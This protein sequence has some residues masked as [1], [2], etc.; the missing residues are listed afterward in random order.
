MI[1]KAQSRIFLSTLLLI[2]FL[3]P[4]QKLTASSSQAEVQLSAPVRISDDNGDDEDPSVMLARDGR[5]YVAWSSKRQDGVNIYIKSSAD[6][7]TWSTEE[8]VTIGPG[9]DY[10]P[11]LAQTRDGTFHIAWF[12]LERA[13]ADIDIWFSR[14]QD[15][16]TWSIPVQITT[17]PKVEWAPS[18]LAD[19][20]DTLRIVWSSGK[21]GN[22]ELFV[23][24]SDDGG[25]QW[26]CERQ[27]TQSDEEDDFPQMIETSKGEWILAWTRY[28]KGSPLLDYIKDTSA[29][30]VIARSRDSLNWS[31]PEVS[32]PPDENGR[33]MDLLPFV[34][35]DAASGQLY[36]SWTSSRSNLWGNILLRNLAS[37]A[38]AYRLLT[39]E[40]TSDYN[41]KISPAKTPGQY[42]MVWV[43][44]REGTREIY[45]RTFHL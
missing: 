17:S 9:E 32:S 15:A 42:L 31:V 10:Y 18:I 37:E 20:R 1:M 14:S 22:R 6:G 36:L 34:F 39:T 40:Q 24:R 38:S 44:D 35:E 21:T 27:I 2:V 25:R 3:W 28:R 43:S 23:S 8:R 16:R 26:S 30:I 11:S 13:Q 7:Q 41:A 29:E 4:N 33:H 12:R 45:S 5:F 19:S